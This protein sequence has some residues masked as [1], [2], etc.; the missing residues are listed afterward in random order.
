M[1]HFNVKLEAKSVT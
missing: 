1:S